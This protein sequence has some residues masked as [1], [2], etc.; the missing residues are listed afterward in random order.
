ML[1]LKED[2]P[3]FALDPVTLQTI[4]RYDFEG[5]VLSP[6]FSAHP[7]IDPVTGELLCFGYEAGGNGND[8]SRDIIVCTIGPDGKKTSEAW[9]EAPYAGY[10]HDFGFTENWVILPLT[11]LKADIEKM[12]KGGNH[13]TWDPTEFAYFGIAPR[14][15]GTKKEDMVWVRT[16]NC[17][18]GH[19]AGTYERDGKLIFDLSMAD[20]NVFHWFPEDGVDIDSQQPPNKFHSPMSRYVFDL[21]NLASNHMIQPSLTE[22]MMAEFSRIDDRYNGKYYTKY[23]ILDYD[24]TKE[25]DFAKVGPPPGGLWNTLFECNW[26]TGKKDGWW[27]GPDTTLQEPVFV[28][29]STDAPEGDGYVLTIV[30]RIAELR[31]DLAILKAGNIAAGPMAIVHLPLRSRMGFHGN[32]VDYSDI[33]EFKDRRGTGGDIGPAK[34]ATELLPWQKRL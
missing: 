24:P 11:P 4:G 32:F 31:Q 9:Y 20:G 26:E 7:K 30:N 21:S 28:P 3:P 12:K 17:F 15:G 6:T 2:G 34:P 16:K 8:A 10:I 14:R 18:Q 19:V 25:Y 27:S 29:S 33:K 22:G 23:W 1:A 5:Q 13:W